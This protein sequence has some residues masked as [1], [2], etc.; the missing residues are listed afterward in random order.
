M[1]KYTLTI[2]IALLF[3]LLN[4]NATPF[5]AAPKG[6]VYGKITDAKTG[7]P[8]FGVIVMVEGSGTGVTTDFEGAYSLIG[9]GNGTYKI[10][11]K[12]LSYKEK[13]VE[14]AINSSE[15]IVLNVSLEDVS[16]DLGPVEVV[17]NYKQESVSSLLIDQKKAVAISDGISADA[18]KRTPDNNTSE[19]MKRV[20]GASIQDNR[21]AII[22]GLNDR[23]NIAFLNGAPLPSTESDR[24][25]FAFDIFPSNMVDKLVITKTA[26][27]DLPADFAGGVINVITRD[28]PEEN[29]YHQYT[30]NTLD[31]ILAR[32][33]QILDKFEKGGK[34]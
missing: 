28:I 13:V 5:Q 1:Q 30:E 4:L 9:L 15:P 34:I 25:A 2:A 29:F 26:T 20:S 14:V 16:T 32:Q 24:R 27:P 8:L 10:K 17:A 21:F 11:F 7:E 3:T 18:I 33:K 6:K 12:L 19:V 31:I 23:Y 22:R